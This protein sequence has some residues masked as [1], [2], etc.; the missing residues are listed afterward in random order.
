MFKTVAIVNPSKVGH[1]ISYCDNIKDLKKQIKDCK[2]LTEM[3]GS[4]KI[5]QIKPIFDVDR[6]HTDIDI[7]YC[8][9]QINIM[10]P[11]KE[12]KWCYRPSREYNNKGIKYSYRF[13]VKGV[14]CNLNRVYLLMI[15]K[16]LKDK[17]KDYGF[18]MTIYGDARVLLLPLTSQ[19][20]KSENKQFDV[21]DVPKLI[22]G[23]TDNIFDCC[24]SYIEE[25]YEDYDEKYDI[26]PIVKKPNDNEPT[27][28]YDKILKD[29]DDE[30]KYSSKSI[31]F[32]KDIINQLSVKRADEYN[33][34]LYVCFAIIGACKKSKIGRRGC[35]DLIHMFSEMCPKKYDEKDIDDWFDDNY[36][37]QMEREKCQYGY[38]YLIHTC[39]K[40]D[41]PEYYDETFNKTYKKIKEEFEKEIIKINDAVLYIQLN[42]HRDIHKPESFYV[43]NKEILKNYYIDIEKFRYIKHV[44]DKKGNIVKEKISIVNKKSDWW[45]DCDKRKVD[46][47]IFQ[48]YKLDDT[49]KDRYFNMFQGFRV[50]FLPVNKDYSLI[51]KV[52]RHIKDVLCNKDE[53]CYDWFLKYFS[54][55]LKGR[56]TNVFPMI[57]GLEGCGKNIILDM[58][59]YGLIGDDYAIASSC[60][61][62]Q[63][64]NN[65]NS[66]LQNR[67]LTII[68]EGTNALRSCVDVIKDV[69]TADKINIEKKGV[70][71]ISLRNYNNF[72]GSTNNFNIM[73]ISITDRRFVWL[74][75]NNEYCGNM[76]YFNPLIDD[77]KDEK[78]LSSLYHYLIE[79]INCP[80]DYD[81]QKTR[82]KTAIYKKLQKMNLPNPITYISS[83]VNNKEILKYRKYKNEVYT[84]I[85]C[86]DLYEKYK[87]W[88]AKFKYEQFTY[89]QFEAKLT[90]DNKYGIITHIDRNKCKVFK[91]IKLDFETQMEKINNLEDLEMIDDGFI[92]DDDDD[93]DL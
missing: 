43:M 55:I 6:Y 51:E 53:Y 25:D 59:A 2:F 8:I 93:D 13:Y 22:L 35:S 37:K 71:A 63:L 83:I 90:D 62:K 20:F 23:N 78:V 56:K 76:D 45:D 87:C 85:K 88:C 46:R 10:Y 86:V 14:R 29:I 47:L 77:V 73:N 68:N 40:E 19:K 57:R 84:T 28:K 3:I 64:F 26:P 4:K 92:D 48:P 72:I 27:I 54:A 91:I 81:F 89:S 79:E 17:L 31:D 42:H 50:E 30:D 69:I 70:D 65:F 32:I 61:E 60:P 49:M 66:L 36:K 24:A 82:P 80:D 58:I 38:S 21:Y 9:E 75:C 7:N 16:G 41:K 74:N 34:W 15:K 11:G 18:D 12:V 1:S 52:L 39:L 44:K 5:K 67:V 33:D